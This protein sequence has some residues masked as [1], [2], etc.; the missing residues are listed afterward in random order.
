M[1]YLVAIALVLAFT[2]LASG[3][4]ADP[5]AHQ[6][7][8]EILVWLQPGQDAQAFAQR[9]QI[10]LLRPFV[11]DSSAFVFSAGSVERSAQLT[12]MLASLPGVRQALQNRTVGLVSQAFVPNDPLY[13]SQ[14]HL[15]NTLGRPHVNAPAAWNQNITGAGVVI[16]V[17]DDGVERTH[18][19]L[20]PNYTASRSYDFVLNQPSQNATGGNRHGT[21]VAGVAAARGGNGIGVTGAAP[22]AAI[23]GL[24]VAFGSAGTLQMFVEASRFRSNATLYDIPIK[25]HSYAEGSTPYADY[26]AIRDAANEG[27]PFGLI[28]VY[29]ASN[30][31]G[32]VLEDSNR[33]ML[34][35]NPHAIVVAAL[36]ANNVY[37]SYSNF[38]ACVTI[39]APSSGASVGITTTDRVGSAGYASGDYTNS[40]GGTSSA[41]PLAAGVIALGKGINS[42][43]DARLTKHLLAVTS[44]RV[45][46]SNNDATSDGGWRQNAA[47]IWFNQ[48]YGFGLI[49]AEGFVNSVAGYEVSAQQVSFSGTQT[50]ST[51]LPDNGSLT[52]TFEL[53]NSTPIEEVLITLNV[54]HTARGQ[55]EAFLTSPSGYTSRLM[56]RYTDTGD[57]LNWTFLTNAFWGEN[58]QGTWS[59]RL[60]DTAA[61]ETGTWNSFS[62]EVRMGTITAIPEPG[63]LL[64]LLGA[65]GGVG[66]WYWRRQRSQA[67]ADG[68]AEAEAEPDSTASE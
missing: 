20:A 14:W 48:N 23:S 28:N 25:N 45:D 52:R 55:L 44:I 26:T 27:V 10:T 56:R 38:G 13:S 1:R 46:P 33:L 3:Q 22:F 57:N 35:N 21:S 68:E 16:G 6:P 24:K 37:S 65:S 64:G 54:S 58:G 66:A 49:N 34:Q 51:A 18:P 40:F 5:Q 42:N 63:T 39:T 29:A 67:I 31:R 9:H 53:T 50:V 17:V 32:G 4:G 36:A 12:P 8:D 60:V 11:T 30:S 2:S 43:L 61:G 59:L 41:S 62:A 15:T 19:D 47:G 7:L